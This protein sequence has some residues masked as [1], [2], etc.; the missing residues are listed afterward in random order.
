LCGYGAT[1]V[2][3]DELAEHLARATCEAAARLGIEVSGEAEGEPSW[4]AFRALTGLEAVPL[5]EP[6]RPEHGELAT[7]LCLQLARPWRRNPRQVA[8][9]V[10]ESLGDAGGLLSRVEVAGPGFINFFFRPQAWLAAIPEVLR[11]G[12]AFGRSQMGRGK[13]VLVEFVSANPTGPLHV[14]H[15]RGAALGDA[16]ARLLAYTG[17]EVTTEYYINDAGRQMSILGRSLLVRARQARGSDEPFPE[18]HYRGEYLRELAEEWLAGEG[19][20]VLE[21][22]EEE[23]VARAAQWAGRRILEGIAEDLAAF[24]VRIQSWYSERSLVER[25]A[26]AEALADLEGRGLLYEHE[27]ALWFRAGRFGDEKDRVVRRSSG[28]LTYFASDI[29]YHR[30]KLERGFT[31]LIDVWGADHHGYVPRLRAAVEALGHPR[32]ALEVVLVQMVSLLRGGEPVAMSTRA[33]EFVTLREVVEEVGAD[34]ARFIFLTR[35]PEAPLD[36]DLEVAKAQSMDNPVYYVQYAHTRVCSLERKAREAGVAPPDPEETDL[37]PLSLEE[38][39]SLARRLAAWPET[40]EGAAAAREP[41]RITHYL[42]QLAGAFH[43]YY[44]AHRILDNPP[45]LTAARFLLALAVGRVLRNGL[46]LLGVSAPE[47]M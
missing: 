15:G 29:A 30:D 25:G 27:G 19:A 42:H 17:H 26:V 33:G 6:K 5:E 21:L 36:F 9:A 44:N 40:V 46:T 22:P 8:E 34:S 13:R 23:A 11:R 4:E 28:E 1:A 16:I 12:E 2:I 20:A 38:E 32:E 45:E 7:S 37:S 31:H 39:V 3:K 43:S 14:G 41:H 47:A 35:R 24:G 18:D 10:C